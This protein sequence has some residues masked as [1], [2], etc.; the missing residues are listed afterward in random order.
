MSAFFGWVKT[1]LNEACRLPG[2]WQHKAIKG[3][4]SSLLILFILA[5][6][7]CLQGDGS[8]HRDLILLMRNPKL[9]LRLKARLTQTHRAR[10]SW[11][12]QKWGAR[13]LR[14]WDSL[15]WLWFL[16]LPPVHR[17]TFKDWN[18]ENHQLENQFSVENWVWGGC[19]IASQEASPDRKCFSI[20]FPP[21]RYHCYCGKWL[22]PLFHQTFLPPGA[23]E[24]LLST[25]MNRLATA[26]S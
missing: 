23:V 25:N 18:G 12:T 5:G 6:C 26:F 11:G 3:W 16:S 24:V 7:L 14:V 2:H 13:A 15:S 9:N 21:H 22:T 17:L 1:E 8:R 4:E 19:F 10:F 20:V